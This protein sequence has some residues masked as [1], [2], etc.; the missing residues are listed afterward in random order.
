MEELLCAA[1][2]KSFYVYFVHLHALQ[3]AKR[4]IY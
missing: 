3:A 2:L 4:L 1:V